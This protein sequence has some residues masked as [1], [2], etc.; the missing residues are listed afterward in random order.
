MVD[1]RT[2]VEVVY[3]GGN[4]ARK[5]DQRSEK[6]G[7]RLS[8]MAQTTREPSPRSKEK[9]HGGAPAG[10]RERTRRN[11]SGS[12]T[13]SRGEERGPTRTTATHCPTHRHRRCSCFY[14]S[15]QETYRDAFSLHSLICR[16]VRR[17]DRFETL[18]TQLHSLVNI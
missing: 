7:P 5:N 3:G 1:E 14:L 11:Q 10:E 16:F 18:D 2:V 8:S 9:R 6:W 4:V 13:R 17:L 15:I 12:V